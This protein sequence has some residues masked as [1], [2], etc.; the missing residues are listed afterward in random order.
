[1][2]AGGSQ[3]GGARVFLRQ[4]LPA[5]RIWGRPDL[6]AGRSGV[7]AAA[8]PGGDEVGGWTVH[9]APAA[10]QKLGTRLRRKVG[11]YRRRGSYRRRS[12]SPA[13]AGLAGD[14]SGCGSGV[15]IVGMGVVR[16]GRMRSVTR[17]VEI[18]FFFFW[19]GRGRFLIETGGAQNNILSTGF[20]I[21]QPYIY[22]YI[23]IYMINTSYSRV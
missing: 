10:A 7:S 12:G 14:E 13:V 8:P 9:G 20:R 18:F 19:I 21:V 5:R 1:M 3:G 17:L 6:R 2:G 15:G 22:I 11:A 16:V 4:R 23:Y